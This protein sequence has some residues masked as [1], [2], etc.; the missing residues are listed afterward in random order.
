MRLVRFPIQNQNF[1]MAVVA[2]RA[3]PPPWRWRSPQQVA[4]H[5]KFLAQTLRTI[6]RPLPGHAHQ[7]VVDLQ[8]QCGA[9]GR[10]QPVSQ[11][12][13]EQFLENQ[14]A[15]VFARQ[16]L[17]MRMPN[18]HGAGADVVQHGGVDQLLR[19]LAQRMSVRQGRP[20]QAVM[21]AQQ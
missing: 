20:Q 11:G 3:N 5:R 13:R 9:V 2:R 15:Q 14:S 21:P 4:V 7:R 17:V 1:E 19:D 6:K 18:T 12:R 10:L 8:L 16:A